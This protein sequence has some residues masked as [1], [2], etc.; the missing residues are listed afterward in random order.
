MQHSERLALSQYRLF[1]IGLS[2][3]QLSNLTLATQFEFLQ[4]GLMSTT[5]WMD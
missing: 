4:I 3:D 2:K 1:T 5:S